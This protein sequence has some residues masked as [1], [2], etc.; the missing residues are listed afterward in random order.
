MLADATSRIGKLT[1]GESRG[2]DDAGDDEGDSWVKVQGP[3]ALAAD[4]KHL[5][6]IRLAD[7]Q[8]DDKTS[9][10]DTNVSEA[11]ELA[12]DVNSIRADSRITKHVQEDTLHVHRSMRVPT[13]TMRVS[14]IVTSSRSMI[15]SLVLFTMRMPMS[16]LGITSSLGMRMTISMAMIVF[17]H[18]CSTRSR[19]R[20]DFS[21]WFEMRSI[22][23][24]TRLRSGMTPCLA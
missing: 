22:S 24:S 14:V 8:P 2:E 10:N 15:M 7:L 9:S 23:R 19:S 21:V 3:S 16:L 11:D 18:C 17:I 5:L 20:V 1:K 13:T 12:Q 4:Y 6:L